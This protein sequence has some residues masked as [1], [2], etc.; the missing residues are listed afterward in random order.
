MFDRPKEFTIEQWSFFKVYACMTMLANIL[1][2]VGGQF[3]WLYIVKQLDMEIISIKEMI[4]TVLMVV[5]SSFMVTRI[6]IDH[7]WR[8]GKISNILITIVGIISDYFVLEHPTVVIFIDVAMMVVFCQIVLQ[9]VQKKINR[10]YQGDAR[11]QFGFQTQM[12]TSV[13][14]F[15]VSGICYICSGMSMETIIHAD[16]ACAIISYI[17]MQLRYS[18]VEQY[19]EK[20]GL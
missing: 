3:I 5:V 2:M 10:I 19:C 15:I 9:G 1:I 20:H 18:I 8:L 7:C 4:A 11:T 14:V 13:S 17:V 16:M 12:C 6:F